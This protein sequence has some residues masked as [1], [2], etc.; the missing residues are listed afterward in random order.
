MKYQAESNISVIYKCRYNQKFKFIIK[1]SLK[2]NE[3]YR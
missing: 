3:L 1:L 2:H